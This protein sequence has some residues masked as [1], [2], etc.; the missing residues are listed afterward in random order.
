M[1]E[2][3]RIRG[4]KGVP[5]TGIDFKNVTL[6]G[7]FKIETEPSNHLTQKKQS[8]KHRKQDGNIVGI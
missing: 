8:S 2:L 7:K 6:T 4:F 3:K 1:N 5:W